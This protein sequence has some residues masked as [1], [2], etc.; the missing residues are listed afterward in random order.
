VNF[1]SDVFPGLWRALRDIVLFWIGHGVK[2]FRVRSRHPETIF[3]AEGFTHPKVM[4]RIAKVG[5][6]QSYSYFT[7]RNLKRELKEYLTELTQEEC[8]HYMRPNFFA[9]T[10]RHQPDLTPA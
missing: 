7:W 8:R 5:F 6:N 2:I 3:L 4:K 1:H 9:N 10:P